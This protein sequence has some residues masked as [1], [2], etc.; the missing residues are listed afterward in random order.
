MGFLGDLFGSKPTVPTWNNISLDQSQTQAI[1]A[2]QASLGSLETLGAG[3]NSFNQ[4]QLTELMNNIMPGFSASAS[5]ASKNIASELSG[6]IPTDVSNA[7]QSSD[8][9]KAL[10]GGF[11]G[12]G[13]S[14]NLTARDLGLTSLDLTN[15]G[16]S[17]LESWSGQIDK[18]FMPGQFNV[19]SMF[20]S[21]Q[22]EFTSTMQNQEQ[23]M[24]Q[25]W[26][27]NQ[28]DAMGDPVTQ[29]LWNMGTSMLGGMGKIASQGVAS[30]MGGA[31]AGA[32]GGGGSGGGGGL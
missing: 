6:Q 28:V 18:M 7:I 29:G 16:L 26:M 19:S 10:T 27:T 5:T 9:A 20:I 4:Q 25:Q 12:S 21:P 1:G 14:G 23:E 11:G 8:A 13:L 32:S 15:Q 31:G 2:N 17:S 3:I 30:S 24:Q 22:D